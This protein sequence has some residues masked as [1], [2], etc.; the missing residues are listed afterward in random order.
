MYEVFQAI[1][2]STLTYEKLRKAGFDTDKDWRDPNLKRVLTWGEVGCFV[3]H[4]ALWEQC[5]DGDETYL[6]FEDDVV[7]D[8]YVG[9]IESDIEGHDLLFLA[10]SEQKKKGIKPVN[11]RLSQTMLS[12]LVGRVRSHSR[13]RAEAGRD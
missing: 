2:G 5:A 10:W 1:D 6:I 4:Y 3:S 8:E 7:C 12:V 13:G 9:S 11:D